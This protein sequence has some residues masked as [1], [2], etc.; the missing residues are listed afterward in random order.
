MNI[1]SINTIRY[2]GP[3]SVEQ[4]VKLALETFDQLISFQ[5]TQYLNHNV[6]TVTGVDGSETSIDAIAVYLVG[7]I[8]EC[9][10]LNLEIRAILFDDHTVLRD[11][12][13]DVTSRVGDDNISD[14]EKRT[15]R[16]P[17]IWEGISHLMLHLSRLGNRSHPPG[18]IVAKTLPNLS[19]KDHGIDLIAL[20][21]TDSL[22]ISA[23]ECKAYLER[24]SE[25]ITD[26]SNFLREIDEKSR[27]AEIRRAIS[28]FRPALSDSQQ[29]M[30]YGAFWHNERAYFPMVCCDADADSDWSMSREVINRLKPPPNRKFLIPLSI[31]S[32]RS[33]FD[34]IA[35]SMRKYAGS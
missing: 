34:A 12:R 30:L 7:A 6:I 23:C 13:V 28:L 14:H 26:A 24:P 29:R 17:W 19:V 18:K 9:I 16:N 31:H 25:A 3:Q 5:P 11:I 33:F 35:D 2:N 22:G 21:G 32:A 15:E 8:A 4:D 10:D 20:Y 1:A 27:D